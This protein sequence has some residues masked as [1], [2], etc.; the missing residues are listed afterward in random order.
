MTLD[1]AHL[2]LNVKKEEPIE[3]IQRVRHSS[4]PGCTIAFRWIAMANQCE[5][6]GII[7][8][9]ANIRCKRPTTRTP[10]ASIGSQKDTQTDA[11]ALPPIESIPSTR[12]NKSRAG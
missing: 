5:L 9:R 12:K 3:V 2:I 11:L 10:T 1:E 8:L 6:I 7:A 4:H